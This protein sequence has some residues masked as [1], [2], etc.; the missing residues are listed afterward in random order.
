MTLS[1]PLIVSRQC[2]VMILTG[3]HIAGCKDF[4]DLM[5]LGNIKFPFYKGIIVLLEPGRIFYYVLHE[6]NASI[7]LFISR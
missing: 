1:G 7:R 4:N 3:K 5:H 2:M 6:F